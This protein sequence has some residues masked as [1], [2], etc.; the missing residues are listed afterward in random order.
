MRLWEGRGGSQAGAP[1]GSTR[2]ILWEREGWERP[3]AEAPGHTETGH[4]QAGAVGGSGRVPSV[5][6]REIPP[7]SRVDPDAAVHAIIDARDVVIEYQPVLDATHGQIVGFEALARGPA[8]PLRTPRRLFAA[9]RAVGRAGE[10]D[11][12]CRA[13]A[14]RTL[15]DAK[16][17][18]SL[19]LFVNVEPDSLI[20]PCPEDLLPIIW[21]AENRLRVFIDVPGQALLRHPVQV[22]E[23]VRRA[24]AAGWGVVLDDLE[25]SAAAVSLLP[26]LEPDVI[27]L[28]QQTIRQGNERAGAA[29]AAAL[30][31][32]ERMGTALLVDSVEEEPG[33]LARTVAAGF[34]QG[35]LL[36]AEGAL[37]AVVPP[38]L[39]PVP[40]RTP[41]A[42][43]RSLWEVVEESS[44]LSASEVRDE[45]L[46]RLMRQFIGQAARGPDLPVVGVVTSIYRATTMETAGQYRATLENCPVSVLIGRDMA[47]F[48][49]W[50]TRVAEPPP[51]HPLEGEL[52]FLAL[53]TTH[54][55][56][57]VARPT[58]VRD[59]RAEAW[60]VVFS[61][62]PLTCRRVMRELLHHMDHLEGGVLSEGEKAR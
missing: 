6:A 45:S 58:S 38:P 46:T 57:L 14:F 40:L 1:G 39:A 61:H 54:S 2:W 9:A 49:D 17:H 16:L 51:G 8:G 50:R 33:S 52:C 25:F 21:E 13:A 26:T 47:V 42:D 55:S 37:P 12:I 60:D 29:L 4:S 31:E 20:T 30:T 59:G 35:R 22:L 62:D 10:L 7:P 5:P 53:S 28:D 23:S 41:T 56:V 36:G 34:L 27:R 3:E 11:W 24:R 32:S 18:P 43:S 19:S 44:R 48:Q 15:M